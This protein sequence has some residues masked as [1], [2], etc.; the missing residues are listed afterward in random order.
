MTEKFAISKAIDNNIIGIDLGTTNS[1]VSILKNSVPEIIPNNLSKNMTPSIVHLGIEETIGEEAKQYLLKDPKN[2]IFGSKRLIGRKFDDHAIQEYLKRI[3]YET[4]AV[5]NGDV[6]IKTDFG[7]FSPAQISAKILGKIRDFAESFTGKE[8]KRAVVTVP[9]YFNDVQRQATKDAGKIANIDVI[10]IVNEPTAAALAYGIDK[11]DSGYIAVYD[12]GGG[13]FDISILELSNGVF[14][15]KATNGDTFL[16]GDDF[17]NEIVKF[18]LRKF[19][20]DEGIKLDNNTHALAR[21]REAAEELKKKLS[22]QPTAKIYLENIIEGADLNIVINQDQIERIVKK[23]AERTIAPCIEAIK[24]ANITV[25]DIKHVIL[26]GGMTRMPTIRNVVKKIFKKEPYTNINPDEAVAKGA[27]I[28]AGILGGTVEDILLLDV[29]PLSLGIEVL[30]GIFSKIVARNTTIPFKHTEVFSTSEDN[31]EE[32]DIKIYQGERSM[33]KDNK[34]LGELKLKNIP[35]APRGIPKIRV[36]FEADANGIIKVT[37]EDE[38]VKKQVSVDLKPD[39]GLSEKEIEAMVKEAQEKR[40]EDKILEDKSKLIIEWKEFLSDIK[41][42][43]FP[44]ELVK[45][46]KTL[47]DLLKNEKITT[48]KFKDRFDEIKKII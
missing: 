14:H 30:G 31:Q 42:L 23:I 12:L 17:D 32:V 6:W 5:C 25:D 40:E 11:K 15:V 36:T 18:I 37:A 21:I 47:D 41:N 3:P 8:I 38:D 27:A 4:Q 33:V 1:V 35:K 48:Q 10:R 9:A 45:K 13:T 22:T 43:V 2:T 39:S 7:K 44:D 46:I 19:E 34:L 26:V 28:Q 16:G 20:E 29:I 24:D